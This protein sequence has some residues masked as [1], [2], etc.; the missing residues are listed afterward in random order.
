MSLAAAAV[1]LAV[2]QTAVSVYGQYKGAQAAEEAAER[3]ELVSQFE[4]VQMRRSARQ[5]VAR[6]A[7]ASERARSGNR[8]ISG[9]SGVS[10]PS[11]DLADRSITTAAQID[12]RIIKGNLKT[13]LRL[14]ELGQTGASIGQFKIG[15]AADILSGGAA[16]IKGFSDANRTTTT[17]TTVT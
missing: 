13:S 5:E 15:A 9:A 1:G 8:A 7:L 11:V 16:A 14:S 4:R 3:N 6:I 2:A 12:K 10:G 17:T